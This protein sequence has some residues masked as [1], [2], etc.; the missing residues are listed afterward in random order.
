MN[1]LHKKLNLTIAAGSALI[2][3]RLRLPAGKCVG[4]A[5][6]KTGAAPDEFV[7]LTVLD[8]GSELVE[9]S[10]Y[11]FYEKTSAGGWIDSLR[12]MRFDCN[13]DVTVRL[14]SNNVLAAEFKVQVIFLIVQ[15]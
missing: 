14:S 9:G 10:D 5:A 12:P 15:E 2:E 6:I 3:N 8:Q 7:D 4:M 11:R 1:Y 13:R